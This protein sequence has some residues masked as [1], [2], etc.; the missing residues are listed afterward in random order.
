VQQQVETIVAFKIPDFNE[1][2]AMAKE[3][4]QKALALLSNKPVQDPALAAERAAAREAKAAAEA[5]KRA[6]K[7]QAEQEAKEAKRA[8]AEAA[9][10]AEEEAR[11]KSIK[12]PKTEAELKAARDAR[13]AARKNRK[14]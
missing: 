4:K 8:A 10:L 6:A 9:R 12:P 3:A 2:T 1:R 5:E 7:R 13:Y 14:G 11:A